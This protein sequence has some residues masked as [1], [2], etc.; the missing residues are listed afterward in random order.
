MQAIGLVEL[1]SVTAAVNILDTM[2]KTSDIKF[3]TWERKQGGRL[4]TII[5]QGDVSAVEEA[6]CAAV[7]T[8]IIKPVAYAVIPNPHEETMK[9]I[10]LSTQKMKK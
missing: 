6:V 7:K 10:N 1:P 2:C 3:L 9:I 4:V 8:A 5:V